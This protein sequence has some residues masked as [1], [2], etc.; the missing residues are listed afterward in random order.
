MHHDREPRS[1]NRPGADRQ[2]D[3]FGPAR[4]HAG[5]ATPTWEGLS[6]Q[7]RDELMVLMRRLIL[8]HAR[9]G[10]VAV[11]AKVRHEP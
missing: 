2:L 4:K 8:D 7:A 9:R 10:G 1:E 3:L 11:I 5:G 6:A